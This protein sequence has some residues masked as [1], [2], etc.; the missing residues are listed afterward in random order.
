MPDLV[1][2]FSRARGVHDERPA[3]AALSD[4]ADAYRYAHGEILLTRTGSLAD[5]GPPISN[6]GRAEMVQPG[7]G[8]A[9]QSENGPVAGVVSVACSTWRRSPTP[10][11]HSCLVAR[12]PPCCLPLGISACVAS[13]H[14]CK[15]SHLRGNGVIPIT[16]T[17]Q[18][19]DTRLRP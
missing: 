12:A 3:T 1:I 16:T 13:Q 2:L 14:G 8:P 17:L 18:R 4:F 11:T 7:L 10:P 5:R 19:N 9:C 15:G 6:S